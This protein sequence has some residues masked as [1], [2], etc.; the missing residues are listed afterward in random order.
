MMTSAGTSIAQFE[1]GREGRAVTEDG[2]AIWRA[3]F[4]VDI[5]PMGPVH[6]Q[7]ALLGNRAAVTLWAERPQSAARLHENSALL[8]E[9]LEQA[10]LEPGDILC[11]TGTPAVPRTSVPAAGRF[12]DRAS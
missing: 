2:R 9:A 11:R 12:L 8:A 4:S 3:R 5:E 10:E 1:I 7:V 6:A